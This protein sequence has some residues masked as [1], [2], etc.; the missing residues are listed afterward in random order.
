MLSNSSQRILLYPVLLPRVKQRYEKSLFSFGAFVI[1]AADLI[2]RFLLL[3]QT[4]I[5]IAIKIP[6]KNDLGTRMVLC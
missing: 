2:P 5:K 6:D 4:A 3:L 1:A